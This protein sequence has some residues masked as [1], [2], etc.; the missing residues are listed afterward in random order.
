MLVVIGIILGLLVFS[1]VLLSNFNL[2]FIE[3]NKN[4]IV[5]FLH[6][7]YKNITMD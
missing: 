1:F 6:K 2:I 4:N 7:F 5:S 3:L